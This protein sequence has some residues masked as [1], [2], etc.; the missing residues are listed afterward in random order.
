MSLI[1]QLFMLSTSYVALCYSS[2][3]GRRL[4]AI[5]AVY[6]GKDR[7]V[8]VLASQFVIQYCHSFLTTG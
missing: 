1:V 2:K 7:F 5:K 4:P 8:W 6:E 3:L